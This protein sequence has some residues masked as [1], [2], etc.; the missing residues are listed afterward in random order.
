VL[1]L[2]CNKRSAYIE[3]PTLLRRRGGSI[4]KCAHVLE[5]TK[6]LLMCLEETKVGND[7]AGKGQ[8]QFNRPI[9]RR[10]GFEHFL[11]YY[12]A[13]CSILLHTICYLANATD[14]PSYVQRVLLKLLL[15]IALHISTGSGHQQL[16]RLLCFRFVIL[17]F[18]V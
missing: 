10:H 1:K 4:S 7:C 17:I 13:Y 12:T 15:Y 9:D 6:I 2:R 18:D 14:S 3:R 16:W 11:Y 5:R 8:Q